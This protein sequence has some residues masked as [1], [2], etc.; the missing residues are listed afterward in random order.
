MTKEKMET[1]L[2]TFSFANS[3]ALLHLLYNKKYKQKYY[4][5]IAENY[6]FLSFFNEP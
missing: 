5:N 3:V 6:S 2:Q 4:K 1:I